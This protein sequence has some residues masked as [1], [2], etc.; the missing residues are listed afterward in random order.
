[1][2]SIPDVQRA[3]ISV[4]RGKPTDSLVLKNDWPVPKELAKDEVLVKVQVAALNP[5]GFKLMRA[6]PN[7]IAKRPYVPENDFSGIVVDANGSKFS[8]GDN[9]YGWI[10]VNQQPVTHQGV[11]AEYTKI[12]ADNIV[13]RPPNV[14]PTQAA[15]ITLAAL[16]SYQALF[17]VAQLEAGQTIFI[18]GGS[19]SVGA[20]AIQLAKIKGAKVVASASAKNEEFVRKMGADEFIDYTKD[21]GVVAYLSK[22]P[23]STKFHVIYDAVGL[24]SPD[25]YTHSKNYLAPNGIFVSTGPLPHKLNCDAIWQWIRTIGAI[26]TP[27]WL[28]NVKSRWAMV[29]VDNN[30]NDMNELQGFLANGSLQPI[31]DSVFEFEDVLK[32]YERIM[33]YHAVG[34]VVVKVDP[35]AL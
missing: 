7:F 18:N 15:G 11:L 21:P 26:I 23:P 28:G 16:A 32:A 9:V 29:N 2:V 5:I 10:S 3:W 27:S 30:T 20:F 35:E 4:R 1:M 24:M 12:P 14:T 33:T 6:M 19:S 25:L 22:N 34:K 13:L 17:K 31:V 8:N